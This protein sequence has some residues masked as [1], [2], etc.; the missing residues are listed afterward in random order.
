MNAALWIVQGLLAVLFLMAGFMKVSLT[1][2]QLK[3]RGMAWTED[4]TSGQ[5]RLIGILEILGTVGVVLPALVGI[6]PILTPLAAVGLALIMVGAAIFHIRR[7]EFTSMLMNLVLF[8]MS[9]FVA[10]GRFVLY[11]L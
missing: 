2:E 5:I 8:A 3:E 1:K 6:L 9:V 11:P 7:G 4:L 10:Y